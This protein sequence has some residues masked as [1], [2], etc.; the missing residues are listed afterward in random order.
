[1]SFVDGIDEAFTTISVPKGWALNTETNKLEFWKQ[2]KGEHTTY[3]WRYIQPPT[4]PKPQRSAIDRPERVPHFIASTFKSYEEF[5]RAYAKAIE[6]KANVTPKI[7][8]LADRITSG[9]SNRRAQ[10]Q[11]IYEWVTHNTRYVSIALGLGNVIPRDAQ[12]VLDSGY[13]DC[14]DYAILLKSLLAAKG[15]VGEIALINI[16]ANYQLSKAPALTELNHAI[17]WLPEFNLY[18]DSTSSV[19]PFGV[20]PFQEYGKPTVLAVTKGDVLHKTPVLPSGLATASLR[21]KAQL[22]TS[23]KLIGS[24]TVEATGPFSISLRLVGAGIQGLGS[25]EAARAY[26]NDSEAGGALEAD[27]FN[28]PAERYSVHGEFDLQYATSIFT[29]SSFYVNPGYRLLAP[30]GDFL[31]G[32][33]ESGISDSEPTPCFSGT[34]TEELSMYP[35]AGYVIGDLPKNVS[36][37]DKEFSFR[38]QWSREGRK[39]TVRR[40][41]EVRMVEALCTGTLRKRAATALSEIEKDRAN[42]L[43]LVRD[44]KSSDANYVSEFDDPIGN[45]KSNPAA[46]LNRA[47]AYKVAKAYDAAIADYDKAI[48]IKTDYVTAYVN[49]GATYG[50]KQL[51]DRAK[52]DLDKAISLDPKNSLGYTARAVLRGQHGD[53]KGGTEDIE[54]AKKL[55]ANDEDFQAAYTYFQVSAGRGDEIIARIDKDAEGRP[56]DAKNLAT[57]AM[58]KMLAKKNDAALADADAALAL[59]ETSK[60]AMNIRA[61]VLI[62]LKRYTEAVQ[63][64]EK[65]EGTTI[66]DVELYLTRGMAK[67]A[68]KKYSEA[69]SDYTRALAIAPDRKDILQLKKEAEGMMQKPK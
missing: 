1:L 23:G 34:Q 68:L 33:L 56:K 8:E 53:M 58:L 3:N 6:V 28:I 67:D 43:V 47:D 14:K 61:N 30:T 31:L 40:D 51:Y 59:D 13:G 16:G 5:G 46:Y 41:L 21:T 64:L 52:S 39:V 4:R 9:E 44:A 22:D 35:P 42:E 50:Y 57:T 2:D 65:V 18:A 10:A 19:A 37:T 54:M 17:T 49:R 66:E 25:R 11:K 60:M 63:T 15:I 26:F 32:P 55:G 69:I 20:L 27:P 36:L 29:G 24:T 48:S 7:Q 45:D 62:S 12:A 38:S